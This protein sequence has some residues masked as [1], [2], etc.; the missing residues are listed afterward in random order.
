M[1]IQSSLK[2]KLFSVETPKTA[3]EAPSQQ[4]PNPGTEDVFE[5]SRSTFG[6][7][8]LGGLVGAVVGGVAGSMSGESAMITSG[9]GAGIATVATLGPHFSEAVKSGLNGDPIND[10]ALTT[11]A[12]FAGGI[13]LTS[14]SAAAG[15][16]AF[17]LDQ[18]VPGS[19]RILSAVMGAA[20]GASV[21]IW[22]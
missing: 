12:I 11:S 7:R 14:F 9:L 21:G 4:A 18:A 1:N 10:V 22:N 3:P 5:S 13:A 2:P 20:A 6:P 19:G 15:L 17:A 8:L 16:S